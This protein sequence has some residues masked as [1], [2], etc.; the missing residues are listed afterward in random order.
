MSS[1]AI[2]Q[3]DAFTDKVFYGNPAAVCILDDWLNEELMSAIAAE[4]NLSETAFVV[5]D[6]HGYKIRWF[7]PNG[8]ISLCGHATLASAHVLFN[9]GL[10]ES[11][12]IEFS[13]PS[14]PLYVEKRGELISMDFP[15]FTT[16]PV[17][18]PTL[19]TEIID[20]SIKEAY[21]S[22]LDY[23]FVLES[24]AQVLAANINLAKLSLRQKRGLVITAV[25]NECDFY[26][27][28]FYPK[29]KIA[30]D[31]VTGSAYCALAPLWA[32]KL[33]KLELNATQGSYRKGNVFCEVGENV[34]KISGF[35]RWFFKG[36]LLI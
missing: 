4:N 1:I 21:E 19:I 16:V 22:S 24:E 18:D 23:V 9:E 6:N 3:V 35:C 20:V 27:R 28:S 2:Y 30:E 31:P 26:V 12:S 33:N 7:T 13:S 8:E 17:K 14:G 36:E 10:T 11:S 29:Y 32:K 5:K 15:K 34:V 25:G